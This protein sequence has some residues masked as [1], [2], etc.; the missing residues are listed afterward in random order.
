MIGA[1]ACQS[2][3]QQ[4]ELPAHARAHTEPVRPAA[5][6][7]AAILFLSSSASAFI[8]GVQLPVDGGARLGYW[9][10]NPEDGML[11]PS[12]AKEE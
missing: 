12:A 5:Q 4:D 7:A 9:L 1:R 11:N 8:T 6:V 3:R 10:N 2:P